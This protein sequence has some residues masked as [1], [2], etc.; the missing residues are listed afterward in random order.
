[1]HFLY[2]ISVGL[3]VLYWPDWLYGPSASRISSF[4]LASRSLGEEVHKQEV[5]HELLFKDTVRSKLD[6]WAN[7]QKYLMANLSA[8]FQEALTVWR[9]QRWPPPQRRS[10]AFSRQ[11]L[12]HFDWLPF[13]GT[14]TLAWNAAEETTCWPG[15]FQRAKNKH[16]KHDGRLDKPSVAQHGGVVEGSSALS[17]LLVH[18]GRV[19]QQELAGDQWPL[20]SNINAPQFTTNYC[21]SDTVGKLNSLFL[22]SRCDWTCTCSTLLI[23]HQ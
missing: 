15:R 21:S 2:C 9:C 6:Y 4:I 10:A 13:S 16:C 17:V 7:S 11:C 5:T 1:M 18:I 22:L 8:I 3:L 19:L 12:Q 20:D 14:N 23:Q